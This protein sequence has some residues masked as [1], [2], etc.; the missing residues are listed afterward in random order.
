[1][2]NDRRLLEALLRDNFGAFVAKAFGTLNPG[3]QYVASPHI[4][5]IAYKL[6]QVRRRKV[7][8]LIINMPPRSLKSI[9]TSVAFPAFFLGHD[10]TKRFICASYSGELAKKHSNDF[11]ALVT[12]DWY[13]RLFPWA[14]IGAFKNSEAEIELEA[15]GLRLAVSVGGTVTGRGGDIIIVDDPLKADDAF[16]EVKRT[17]ANTWFTNTLLSRLDD[18]TT[19]AIIIVMQRV[20]TDDLTGHVLREAGDWDLLS[21]PAIAEV[22]EEIP[23]SA[24]EF[25]VRRRG[26]PLTDREPLS[27]LEEHRKI[28]G[29]DAFSAQYQQAP[30]PPGGAMIK[31]EWIKRYVMRPSPRETFMIVQSWDTAMKG[32]PNN[33]WSVCT[34]WAIDKD[35]RWFLLDVW[36]NRVDFPSLRN[37]AIEHALCWRPHRILVEDAGSGTSLLQE[38]RGKVSF[39]KPI[40]PTSDK[41]ERMSRASA[42]IERGE[43]FLPEKAAWLAELERELFGFP[44]ERH[45]DQCDSISQALNDELLGSWT[46]IVAK[47]RAEKMEREAPRPGGPATA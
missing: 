17:G 22:D 2:S 31:R 18:K 23:V 40:N 6:D 8:R 33:D 15:R 4:A 32:G 16:S 13:R 9:M 3:Q 25:F 36:R 35:Q 29:S 28:L 12:A 20:H 41:I 14:R 19:G 24:T 7:R 42:K 27:I 46:L 45:D 37:K 1:M 5:A 11:R 30:V 44:N 26:D 39:L 21:L 10:P 43:V 47:Q 34:T 38:L